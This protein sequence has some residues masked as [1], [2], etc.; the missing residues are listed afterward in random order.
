[1]ELREYLDVLRRRWVSV[2][3]VTLVMVAAAS[4][5]TLATTPRYTATT[6]L[7]FAVEGGQSVTDLAQGS[8]FAEKQMTSYAEVATSPLVLDAV[9]DRLGLSTDAVRLADSVTATVPPETVIIE[10]AVT[11]PDAQQAA[12]IA[13]AIGAKVS[14]VAADLSPG[15]DGGGSAVRAT[16]LAPALVPEAPSSPRV[17][18]NLGVAGILGLLLGLGVALLWHVLDTKVRSEADVRALT[19]SPVLGVIGYDEKVP[20]HPVFLRDAPMSGAAEAV[21]RLRTNLQFTDLGDRPRS[22]VISSS[23]PGEGKTTTALNLSVSLADAGS[24]VILVDAD[25]RRPSVADCLGLEGRVG[26]TTVLIGR[27]EVADVVQ[28]WQDSTL[29]VLPSGRIPPNPSELLGSKAMERLLALLTKS[30]DVVIM[31]SPPLLPVTDAAVLSNLAGGSLLVVGAD[32]IH[33]PQLVEAIDTLAAA[34]AHVHGVV[35]NKIAR[36][37]ASQYV[38]DAG[39]TPQADRVERVE[40]VDR[41]EPVDAEQTQVTDSSGGQLLDGDAAE[42]ASPAG[43]RFNPPDVRR[44]SAVGQ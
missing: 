31:D 14:E 36:Q 42:S 37:D 40:H 18:R 22:I 35:L 44:A 28:P 27:A 5:L 30:Y 17:A 33:R 39:Y 13:N 21:R 6:R 16:T 29:D 8:T 9:I 24:R 41:I 23:I 3:V 15:R 26:L 11:D 34:G 32:R 10:I 4:A 7:F 12:R 25:L 43:E 20:S 2:V 38:Y 1:M 19:D